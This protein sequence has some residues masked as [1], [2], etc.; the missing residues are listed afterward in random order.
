MTLENINHNIVYSRE[1]K[2][3]IF[4]KYSDS[5]NSSGSI[6]IDINDKYLFEYNNNQNYSNIT[7]LN[8]KYEASNNLIIDNYSINFKDLIISN[9]ELDNYRNFFNRML[10]PYNSIVN[11]YDFIFKV[12]DIAYNS[13]LKIFNS[14]TRLNYNEDLFSSRFFIEKYIGNLLKLNLQIFIDINKLNIGNINLN[15]IKNI[16]KN[17]NYNYRVDNDNNII[18]QEFVYILYND[19]FEE[20]IDFSL[21]ILNDNKVFF[22]NNSIVITSD[23]IKSNLDLTGEKVFENIYENNP[24]INILDEIQNKIFLS[25]ND[26]SY[27]LTGLNERNIYNNIIQD[28]EK[29]Y[30]YNYDPSLIINYQVNTDNLKYSETLREASNNNLFLLRLENNDIYNCFNNNFISRQNYETMDNDD[31]FKI[32]VTYSI[33]NEISNNN[34]QIIED[35]DIDTIYLN[36]RPV[37]RN[38]LIYN[39]NNFSYYNPDISNI[40]HTNSFI[41]DL[42]DYI[43]IDL[44]KNLLDTNN[45]ILDNLTYEFTDISYTNDFN[46]YEFKTK[47][48]IIFNK[49]KILELNKIKL[50]IFE[51]KFKILYINNFNSELYSE[52]LN[53]QTLDD[54]TFSSNLNSIMSNFYIIDN[55]IN[56]TYKFDIANILLDNYFK[57]LLRN[58]KKIIINFGIVSFPNNE[59]Y[60]NF[61]QLNPDYYNELIELNE[62]NIKKMLSDLN[63]INYLLEQL[64]EGILKEHILTNIINDSNLINDTVNNNIEGINLLLDINSNFYNILNKSENIRYLIRNRLSE[65]SQYIDSISDVYSDVFTLNGTDLIFYQLKNNFNILINR[66]INDL[67][68]IYRTSITETNT[69]INN[70]SNNDTSLN[71]CNDISNLNLIILDFS[72]NFYNYYDILSR[73]YDSENINLSF[74][75]NNEDICGSQIL[76][77]SKK[78]NS[79]SLKFN[80]NYN[81]YFFINKNLENITVDITIP[82]IAPPAISFKNPDLSLN[83]INSDSRNDKIDIIIEKLINDI[84]I[85]DSNQSFNNVTKNNTIYTY[86]DLSDS[87]IK[88]KYVIYSQVEFDITNVANPEFGLGE[89]S[90]YVDIEYKVTDNANNSNSIIRSILVNKSQNDPFFKYFDTNINTFI[91]LNGNEAF[92]FNLIVGKNL[93]NTDPELLLNLTAFDPEGILGD[94]SLNLDSSNV[95]LDLSDVSLNIPGIYGVNS[96]G[97][98]D[99]NTA[100]IT[101]TVTGSNSGLTGILKR[102]IKILPKIDERDIVKHCCYPKVFYKEIQDNYKLGSEASTTRR[103]AKFIINRHI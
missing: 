102:A 74:T 91:D 18:F 58:T 27:N 56:I 36:N 39:P 20:I 61:L 66:S 97:E 41:I 68:N 53:F 62:D 70:L 47:Q 87:L 77:H 57:E 22:K 46:L 85:T 17:S 88:N 16:I 89:K 96:F 49:I 50:L 94:I 23:I 33:N 52:V 78:S 32:S 83:Q 5:V 86:T 95:T 101:Y 59:V 6:E 71:S 100:P 82:D 60:N 93:E 98:I 80:I 54:I 48:A 55:L 19:R 73:N 11:N 31:G 81:T 65:T 37:K 30:F 45:F 28:R 12:N 103:L 24:S 40:L 21:S 25:V 38:N 10:I 84:D 26:S 15:F 67:S 44:Y 79:I 42:N 72:T 1:N 75:L 34:T 3:I 63:L 69:L 14:G 8:F 92:Y 43:N 76:I 7:Y 2:Q 35:F 90:K 64:V 4:R 13:D 51:L 9:G 29:I 99:F